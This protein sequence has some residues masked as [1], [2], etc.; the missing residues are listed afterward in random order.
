MSDFDRAAH[1]RRI[2]TLGGQAT[3]RLHGSEH[4]AAMGRHGFSVALQLGWGPWLAGK[5][6]ASYIAKFGR[7]IVLGPAALAKARARAQARRIYGGM[8]CDVPGCGERGQVH[9]VHGVEAGN[10]EHN[11]VVLCEAHHRELHRAA[12]R[13]R[14]LARE[15]RRAWTARST[16]P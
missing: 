14:R 7:P 6:Q 8:P 10:G 15:E 1:C 3:L 16:C 4:F 2:A 5:L 12:R 9:H 13:S 11:I